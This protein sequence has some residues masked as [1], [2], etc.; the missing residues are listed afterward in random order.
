[1]N[2]RNNCF[3]FIFSLYFFQLYSNPYNYPFNLIK[4]LTDR[5]RRGFTIL[6]IN[7]EPISPALILGARPYCVSV[8]MSEN[9]NVIE[10][11]GNKDQLEHAVLLNTKATE[12]T[13]NKLGECEHF[14]I[15][16]ALNPNDFCKNPSR[17]IDILTTLGDYLCIQITE[18]ALALAKEKGG[19]T[20]AQTFNT[21]SQEK[22]YFLMFECKKK[23]IVRPSWNAQSKYGYYQI[24]SDDIKKVLYIPT[25]NR[26][27]FWH[28]GIN[29]ETFK[30]LNGIWPS[31]I[32]IERQLKELDDATDIIVHGTTLIEN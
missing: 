3:L 10:Q 26:Y 1:M 12:D 25:K 13:L 8:L 30:A 14:D 20:I 17:Y 9:P 18:T 15:V 29:F 31:P 32:T 4:T 28:A 27:T 5:Y 23:S 21:L 6:D 22:I 7:P 16:L 2:Y 24:T 19:K 11:Y